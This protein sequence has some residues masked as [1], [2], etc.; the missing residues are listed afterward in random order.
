MD[1]DHDKDKQG[2]PL[3]TDLPLHEQ[4]QSPTPPSDS[5]PTPDSAPQL[6]LHLTLSN[7]GQDGAHSCGRS[8]EGIASPPASGPAS[9]SAA[10]S[11]EDLE[12]PT[13][14]YVHIAGT[15]LEWILSYIPE[16]RQRL[17]IF[18]AQYDK[19]R[20]GELD[21]L[22]AR[23]AEEAWNAYFDRFQVGALS[24]ERFS[25][26]CPCVDFVMDFLCALKMYRAELR[27]PFLSLC[28]WWS[29][30]RQGTRD[31][32]SEIERRRPGGEGTWA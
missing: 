13:R 23:G 12:G 2:T 18:V 32:E 1:N 19:D 7:A 15:D 22:W 17:R 10:G 4:P 9:G 3:P 25:Y 29:G 21:E 16:G 28:A 5:V 26:T 27:P 30:A 8:A 24:T 11:G 20:L 31:L 6:P 14:E